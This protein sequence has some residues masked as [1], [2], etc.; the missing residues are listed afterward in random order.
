MNAIS[1]GANNILTDGATI[2]STELDLLDGGI[3][4]DELTDSGTLTATTVDINGGA[5]DGTAIGASTPSSG[6]FTT[7][8]STG[9]TTLGDGSCNRRH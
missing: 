8:S 5:I 1:I 4:L 6:A 2:A 7:L 9:I 3:T